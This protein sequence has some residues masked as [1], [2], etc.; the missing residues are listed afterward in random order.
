[1]I[2][3]SACVICDA[4]IRPLK[5][6]LVAPF[7]AKRIWNRDPFCIDLVQCQACGFMFYNP[8]LDDADL[9]RHYSGYRSAEYLSQRRFFE[10][11][12]TEKFNA[13]LASPAHY[14]SRRAKLKPIFDQHLRG[15]QIT[16]VLDYG[17][18][19]GD[20]ML[21]L[22]G[23][24]QL[25]LYDISG[26]DPAPGVTA[27]A[28]PDCNADLI[29]NSN[30][31]EHVGFPRQMVSDILKAAPPGGLVFLE[32]PTEAALGI[33][34]FMRRIAQ[35]AITS[36]FR[37]SLAPHILRRAS[38]YMMHEHVNYFT[39]RSLATLMQKCG[40]KVLASGFYSLVARAGDEG[41]VWCFGEKS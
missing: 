20:L 15:R 29:L 6:A 22:F 30:V 31:L 34:R 12:Y 11:W 35:T 24:A 4:P 1:M 8:R 36:A 16:R 27:V 2:E 41:I 17:G 37:L 32:V 38:L 28:R 18:D 40:G 7:L 33:N 21:G 13:D 3:V 39:E 25:L 5:R 23:A 9:A 19:H 14:E 26:A 10:P